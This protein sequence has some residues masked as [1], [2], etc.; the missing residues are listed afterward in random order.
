MKRLLIAYTSHSGSTREIAEFMCRVLPVQGRQIDVL[1]ISKVTDLSPYQSVIAGGLVYRFG[2]HSEIMGFL[3]KNLL[4]L[5]EKK[6]ALFATALR[7]VKTPDC[8]Q[9]P[10]PVF[11]DPSL[12]P[13]NP[14][15]K[16]A[17]DSYT[18]IKGYL[19]QALPTIQDINPVGL[20]FFA[21]KLDLHTLNLPEKMIM[22]LL[23]LLTN[24]QT[25]DYR[26]WQAIKAWVN[27]LSL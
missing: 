26:N 12:L 10:Y 21:G 13:A 20:G 25:G 9:S 6:V 16:N 17:L 19:R 7:L 11:I 14:Q 24:K 23:M 3:E 18:T 2:W 8:D 1:P 27:H 4:V 5:Q 15:Q 22:V